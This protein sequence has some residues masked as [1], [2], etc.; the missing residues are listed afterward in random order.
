MK[1][2]NINFYVCI[3]CV[4]IISFGALIIVKHNEVA[5]IINRITYDE[6]D[7]YSY[8]ELKEINNRLSSDNRNNPMRTCILGYI[9]YK[10]YNYDTAIEYF[11][12]VINS[13]SDDYFSKELAYIGIMQIHYDNNELELGDAARKKL[14]K[15]Y[16]KYNNDDIKWYGDIIYARELL[17]NEMYNEAIAVVKETVDLNVGY[18]KL[19][20][21]FSILSKIYTSIDSFEVAKLYANNALVTSY[22]IGDKEYIIQALLNCAQTYYYR[23]SYP[24]TIS[25]CNKILDEYDDVPLDYA[26]YV[27]RYLYDSYLSISDLRSAKMIETLYKDRIEDLPKHEKQME[28]IR[29]YSSLS[30]YYSS[31][32]ST[33]EALYY[34]NLASRY[35][36]DKNGNLAFLIEKARLDYEYVISSGDNYDLLL[37]EYE[38]LLDNY[39]N[40][41][42]ENNLKRKIIS[43]IINISNVTK[44]YEK[45]KY[46]LEIFGVTEQNNYNLKNYKLGDMIEECE[47]EIISKAK[48]EVTYRCIIIIMLFTFLIFFFI[49]SIKINKLNNEL[50]ELIE[51]DSLTQL[52]NKRYIY[53][54]LSNLV[55]LNQEVIVAVIDID[56]FK[57]FNDNY[58]HIKGDRILSK[59]ADIIKRSFEEDIVGR[60]GGEEFCII[61]T[62]DYSGFKNDI[63]SFFKKLEE[64]NI[65]HSYSPISSRITV[66]IGVE[67]YS[68][69]KQVHI[70]EL[71]EKSDKK[72]YI[73][74][75][76]GRNR[77]TF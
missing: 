51:I 5:Q 25:I 76:K 40:N 67:R 2:K 26:I 7:R 43:S 60:F 46:Y 52:K 18:K 14:T 45:L 75:I 22:N 3:L 24:E 27:Y 35:E 23:N 72:M 9:E 20:K 28:Y 54:Y 44:N 71:I 19:T 57:L 32:E 66:S 48:Q 11:S 58:G 34:L 1:K 73:S 36:Y 30:M 6:L 41:Y 63:I 33:D 59:V 47:A 8:E 39:R 74:K 17:E 29:I 37:E 4:L 61:S 53:N 65:E 31:V 62:R 21:S 42:F 68:L 38:A 13:N 77:Y 64:E 15:L 16:K 56:Y 69:E 55:G 50:K 70:D 49:K 10:L 12:N